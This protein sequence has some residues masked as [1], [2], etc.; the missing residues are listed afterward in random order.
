MESE[1]SLEVNGE[2]VASASTIRR[3]VRFWKHRL[4]CDLLRISKKKLPESHFDNL[5]VSKP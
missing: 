4:L 3:R 2:L 5:I 1:L